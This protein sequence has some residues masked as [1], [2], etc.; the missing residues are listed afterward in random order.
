MP[1][2][3]LRRQSPT[4]LSPSPSPPPTRASSPKPSSVFED[5]DRDFVMATSRPTSL[6][7]V[8]PSTATSGTT[9]P[10]SLREILTN[11]AP[12]PYTLSAFMAFLSQNHCLETLEFTMDAER[13]KAS[14]FDIL[15]DQSSWMGDANEHVCSLWQKLMRAYILPYGPREVNLPAHVRDRLLSLPASPTPPQPSE[16]DEA[17][18]IVYELMN[19]SVLG[20]FL[21]SVATPMS[22]S[23]E[24]ESRDS[25]SGRTRLRTPKDLAS[26]SSSTNDEP[27]RSPKTSFLP[28]LSMGWSSDP[29]HRTGSSSSEPVEREAGL[30]DDTGSAGSPPANEPMTPPTTPPTSDWAFSTSPGSLHRAISAHN[31]GWKKMG[32]KLGLSRKGRNKRSHTTS[33][34]SAGVDPDVMSIPDT[35][36]TTSLEQT[37]LASTD[38]IAV[39]ETTPTVRRSGEW[40]EPHPGQRYPF[41]D[42]GNAG[43]VGAQTNRDGAHKGG[44]AAKGYAP[45]PCRGRGAVY[46]RLSHPRVRRT[47]LR[48]LKIPIHILEEAGK[49]SSGAN[50]LRSNNSSVLPLIERPVPRALPPADPPASPMTMDEAFETDS[51]K[52]GEGLALASDTADITPVSELSSPRLSMTDFSNHLNMAFGDTM[53]QCSYGTPDSLE[54]M[55]YSHDTIVTAPGED[56]YGW[57]AE[58][59]RKLEV[60]CPA[61]IQFRRVG[62]AK[63][64]LLHRV[65]SLGPRET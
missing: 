2:A 12:P 29:V 18:T 52:G 10:P 42:D 22:E 51:E 7:I 46:R 38:I 19:D 3:R 49:R 25:R 14:H 33:A 24:E 56:R 16:L 20:P 27:N 15:R 13:Y 11:T 8:P 55:I 6:A 63:R 17:V 41:S 21:E 23:M 5:D 45:Y 35:P 32:A 47:S 61:T 64:S 39:D 48:P 54:P 50:A 59:D 65:F 34:T 40:E 30:S 43:W 58:L 57:E 31:N 44:M 36:S 62:G 60:S 37:S 28:L 1:R 26:S 53:G 4:F 9:S